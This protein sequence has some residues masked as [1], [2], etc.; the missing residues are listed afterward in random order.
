EVWSRRPPTPAVKPA[1]FGPEQM[2]E[3]AVGKPSKAFGEPYQPF[4]ADRFIARLPGPP[5]QFIDRV[6]TAEAPPWKMAAGGRVEAEYDV[7][8]DA[9]YFAAD[10]Q[11]QMPF[12]VVQEVALQSCGFLA[13]YMG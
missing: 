3:F 9:W 5:Y 4:D 12:A 2:L 13:A 6:T 7:P 10:C 11:P 8:R 1:L